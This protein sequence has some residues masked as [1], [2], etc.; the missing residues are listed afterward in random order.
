MAD[1]S[2]VLN[3]SYAL[4]FHGTTVAYRYWC[5]KS[6]KP[7]AMTVTI[8]CLTTWKF[9]VSSFK[10][11]YD[12]TCSYTTVNQACTLGWLM[13]DDE[14]AFL[15]M[16]PALSYA[17]DMQL[18]KVLQCTPDGTLVGEICA[19]CMSTWLLQ[20]IT[21]AAWPALRFSSDGFEALGN[22]GF[23]DCPRSRRESSWSSQA[24]DHQREGQVNGNT[25]TQASDPQVRIYHLS[26][27]GLDLMGSVW[28]VTLM[29]SRG[30]EPAGQSLSLTGPLSLFTPSIYSLGRKN[31]YVPLHLKSCTDWSVKTPRHSSEFH[32]YCS[33]TTYCQPIHW[34]S[35]H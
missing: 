19:I 8:C 6:K 24:E 13:A 23:A 7:F 25:A 21:S 14:C 10:S 17:L 30:L 12:Y 33:F 28:P 2:I 20:S 16:H 18:I 31:L 3:A 34:S 4:L 11:A 27:S 22:G 5:C 15:E 1:L 29:T 32:L 26:R 9:H 35:G